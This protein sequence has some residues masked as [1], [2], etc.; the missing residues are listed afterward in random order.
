MKIVYTREEV[1]CLMRSAVKYGAVRGSSISELYLS[2]EVE[3][4]VRD[5]VENILN[6]HNR[7]HQ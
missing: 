2:E 1:L 6:M 7:D 4:E 3:K 5:D